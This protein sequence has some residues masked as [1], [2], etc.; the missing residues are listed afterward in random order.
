MS[1]PLRF[2]TAGLRGAVGARRSRMNVAVVTAA[3]AVW[4]PT[5]TMWSA[6][7]RAS[8]S[9]AMPARFG[10]V[11]RRHVRCARRGRTPGA[12]AAAAT[13]HPVTAFAVRTLGADAG[14]MITASHNPPADN[15]YKVYLGGRA[16]AEDHARECRSW[17]PADSQIAARIDACAPPTRGFRWHRWIPPTP[18]QVWPR[19][20]SPESPPTARGPIRPRSGLC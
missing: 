2:G 8:W 18:W 11:H 9:A 3:T 6:P 19:T 20:T 4:P 14:I 5:F 10:G 16:V 7:M 12:G 17:P 13:A 15:G 1:G